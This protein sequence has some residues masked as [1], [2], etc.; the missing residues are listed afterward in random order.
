M[1]KYTYLYLYNYAE[2][3]QGM[4]G[5]SVPAGTESKLM[6]VGSWG[7]HRRVAPWDS[8]FFRPNFVWCHT[9]TSVETEKQW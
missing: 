7:F 9:G 8:S 1:Y 3:I 2:R 6:I 5:A 4:S